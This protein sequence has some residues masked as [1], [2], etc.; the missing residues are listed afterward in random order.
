MAPAGGDGH[1]AGASS[2][3]AASNQVLPKASAIVS[4][5]TV[6]DQH[7]KQVFSALRR[8]LTKDPPWGVKVTVELHGPPV[9]WWMTDPRGPAFEAAIEAL[10]MG[11]KKKPVAIGCGR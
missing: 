10:Q 4:V 1:R 9:S 2:I 5:R 11:F 7:S 8:F 3:Q 6:P